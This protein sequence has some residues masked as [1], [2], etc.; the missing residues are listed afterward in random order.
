MA[1]DLEFWTHEAPSTYSIS[2]TSK[3]QTWE[4][5]SAWVMGFE[6]DEVL[7]KCKGLLQSAAPG[8]TWSK[9]GAVFIQPEELACRAA[10]SLKAATRH[11]AIAEAESRCNSDIVLEHSPEP[12]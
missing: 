9:D 5:F 1:L 3:F 6:G 7:E 12:S 10:D 11:I 2:P 8:L 4:D